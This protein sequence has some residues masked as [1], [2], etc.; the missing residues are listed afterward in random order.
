MLRIGITLLSVGLPLAARAQ[1]AAERDGVERLR[2][3]LAAAADT[4]GLAHRESLTIARAKRDRDNALLH[5]ELGFLAQRLGDLTGDKRH[6][7]D[8]ASEFEWAADLRPEWPYAWYGLGLAELALGEHPFHAVEN[9]RQALGKDYLSKAAGAFAR[10]ARADPAFAQA[11]IDLALTA[12]KQRVRARVDVAHEALREAAATSAAS[13]PPLQLA[14]G[15]IEREAGEGDSALIAFR[16]FLEVGG[17]SGV[18]LLETARTLFF[19]RRPA[20][21]SQAYYAGVGGTPSS[22]AVALYRGDLAWIARPDELAR[23][24][25]LRPGE[26]R[27]WLREFWERRDGED[28]RRRGERLAEHY[29]RYFHALRNYRLVSVHRH[30]DITETYRSEQRVLDDRGVIYLRHGEPDRRGS[31]TSPSVEPNE[32]WAYDG[33]GGEEPRI[34]HFVARDDVQDYKLVESLADALG[35]RVAIALGGGAVLPTA[36]A[37][38]ESRAALDPVYQR[39]GALGS[40]MNRSSL[41]ADERTRGRETIR[42]GT[43]SDSYALR[44]RHRLIPVARELAVGSGNGGASRLLVPFAIPGKALV[45]FTRGQSVVYPIDLRLIA[46]R[47]DGLTR[48]VD[49]V[50][51]FSAGR[52]LGEREHL[53]GLVELPLPPGMYRVRLVVTQPDGETGGVV[54]R[55]GVAVPAFDAGP[56]TLSDVVVGRRGDG[57]VWVDRGDSIPLTALAVFPEGSSLELYF[58]IHGLP[59]GARYRSRIAVEREGRGGLFGLFGGR[60][61]PVSLEYDGAVEVAP[62]K[63]RQTVNVGS[64]RPGRYRLVVTVRGGPGDVGHTRAVRFTIGLRQPS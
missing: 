8:A 6:F 48:T 53:T 1:S 20:D 30:Y 29:R 23:F 58:E 61:T 5:L 9:L 25:A 37:L 15:R 34:F 57:P 52:R 56:L 4:A 38:F 28:G 50:R 2:A 64:L 27:G 21:G 55:G 19:A 13:S 10:A 47:A 35:L 36:T 24:D 39:L 60:R 49:T 41:L 22:E 18:G 59:P 54:A 40:A 14:R 31:F 44:F 17:D 62:A 33:A 3:E 7:D 12:L 43:T 63:V 32:S 51:T 45:P 42:V 26:Y 46:E 16:R 11:V